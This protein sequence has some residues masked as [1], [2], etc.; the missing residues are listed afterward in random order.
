L[1]CA[2]SLSANGV[3]ALRCG[4]GGRGLE[5]SASLRYGRDG[6]LKKRES[7]FE[8]GDGGHNKRTQEVGGM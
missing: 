3:P 2:G 1:R 6:T 7:L 8:K 5:R 4:N